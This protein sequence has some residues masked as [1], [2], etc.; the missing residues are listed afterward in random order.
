MCASRPTDRLI[1]P[2]HRR[3]VSHHVQDHMRGLL[4]LLLL[5]AAEVRREG[6]GM[7]GGDGRRPVHRSFA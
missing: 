2:S 4:L 1:D 5:A 7:A 3:T 6:A